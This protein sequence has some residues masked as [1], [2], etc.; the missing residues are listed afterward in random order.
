MR[1]LPMFGL[2]HGNRSAVTCDLKCDNACSRPAP[3]TSCEPTFQSVASAALSRRAL[4]AG[5]GAL[6]AAAAMPIVHAQEAEAS[7][8]AAG[9]LK[10]TPIASVDST[11][12]AF[13]VPKGFRWDP[14][15]R[16]GDP[17][18]KNSPAFDPTKPSAKAQA[19]QFGYNNDYLDIIETNRGGTEA[20]L[21]CN[22]EYTN[23]AIMFPPA[24]TADEEAEVLRTLKAAHGFAVVELERRR[25]GEKWSYVRGGY[26]NR[27][28]T[29]D[30][31]FA[32][33]GPA[34][35]SDLLKT[36][37]DPEGRVA[38][39]TF[40]NCSGGTTP[41]GTVLSGEENFN[42]Y[43][44]ADPAARGSKR[45]G[46]TNAASSYGW[47]KIDPRFDATQADY[48][49]EPNRFGYIVEIDP[50]DPKST[51]VKHTAMGRMK[52]EGANVRVDDDGT[53]VAYMGDDEKF[54]YLYKFVAKNK[55]RKGDSRA[56]RKHN[57][58]LLS[59]GDLYVAKFSGV[60]R[61]DN[62][63]LG[64]GE[65]IP[66]TKNGKSAVAGFTLEEVLIFTR[67]AADAVKATPMDRCEDVQP[68]LKTGRVYVVCTNNDARGTAGKPATDAPNPRT[69]NK[70]GHIIEITERR[71]RADATK[72]EWDLF[73]VCGDNGQA[74]TYFGG[75]EGPV[76]PISCPDNIAFDSAGNLWISTDGQP[77]SIKKNDGLFKVPLHGRERGHLVQF[78]AVP[79]QAE[80]CG[81]VIH[82]QDGSV[83]VAVQHPGEEGTWA[84][85]N[86][87][88]PDYVAAGAK[89]GKGDWRG[90]R[91]AV[92]QVTRR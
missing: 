52:H 26:H 72:F 34:A 83:F 8:R 68:D 90:P 63:N 91:P 78:L 57:L 32:F 43:F 25:R 38:L 60:Q 92:V 23:R 15:I 29:A 81:P 16:W 10:F 69:A 61:E 31:P 54:D 45:Y 1:N 46:L 37:A 48:A 55:Y 62:A 4:L 41:W 17:L 51:P 35:G 59:E 2:T 19:L 36:K 18:F 67:E 49:H 40:G 84:A 9:G 87:Y 50:T 3:N 24:T 89:P 65:W 5:G 47:E 80:T 56:A 79:V 85:Q 64:T 13:T 12:D 30:T 73:L 58:K 22:H 71:G 74:G 53:V 77:S 27:R 70:N 66:L 82:D 21:V 44:V 39:G 14:I 20:L 76:A 7:S 28:I 42:G 11:K 6:A 33:D 86:S 75:W 88:F